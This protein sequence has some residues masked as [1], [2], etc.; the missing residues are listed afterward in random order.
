MG[1]AGSLGAASGGDPAR[2]GAAVNPYLPLCGL[3]HLPGTFLGGYQTAGGKGGGGGNSMGR[4]ALNTCFAIWG[5]ES[6]LRFP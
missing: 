5:M 6:N 2:R 3:L 1:S 4:Q